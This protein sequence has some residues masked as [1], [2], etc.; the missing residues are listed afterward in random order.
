MAEKEDIKVTDQTTVNR[1]KPSLNFCVF[2]CSQVMSILEDIGWKSNGFHLLDD[3]R[4][5][6]NIYL[7]N[8]EVNKRFTVTLDVMTVSVELEYSRDDKNH[9]ATAK[10][11]AMI[12]DHDFTKYQ[13]NELRN[14]PAHMK[15]ITDFLVS[16]GSGVFHY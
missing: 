2:L 16:N 10:I 12:T 7:Y 9:N 6:S 1:N 14:I 3:G 4:F 11:S 8:S 13:I 5:V 15:P